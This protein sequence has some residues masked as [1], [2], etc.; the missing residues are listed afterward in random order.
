MES[1]MSKRKNVAIVG[2]TGSGK[3]LLLS[4]FLYNAKVFDRISIKQIDTDPIEEA[5]GSSVTSHV[6]SFNWKEDL[7][8]AI[9][10]PGFGD[11]IADVINAIFVCENVLSVINGVAGVEIQTERTWQIAEDFN[12]PVMVFVNQLDKERSSF[13]NS[14]ESLKSSFGAKVTPL[15]LPI[16]SES[17]FKGVVDLIKMK[18]FVYQNGKPSEIPI[19]DDLKKQ[20]DEMRLKMVEDIVES[21]DSLMEKYLEGQEISSEELIKALINAYKKRLVIPVFCGSAEKNI[22]IDV[23]LDYISQIGATPLDCPKYKA[24]LEDGTEIEVQVTPNEPFCAYNFKTIVDPF[25]GRV[26]YIKVIAGTIKPGDSYVNVNR[27]LTDKFG[28]L[29]RAMG[30][31][32]VEVEEAISGD[33]IV[34]PKLKEGG[35]GETLAHR[36]RK[37]MIIPPAF[38]EPMFSRSVN[39]KS[40]TDID[41]IS[42]GLSRLAET[43]PTF[44]WEYDPETGETVVSGIGTVHLDTMIERLKTIFG[45]DVEVGKPKIAYRETITKKVVA[46]YKHKKQTGGHGQYG[47]VKIEM[48][49][50]PRGAGFEFVDKI[51]GGAI[52][53]NYIPAV[54]KGIIE[55][56][57]RGSLAGYPVVDVR[58]TLFDGSYHEVD[59]SDISF[60]IAA[61]QAFRKGMEEAKPV[62]LEPIM[63]VEVFCPDEVAGDVIG[64]ITARRGRPQGMEPVGRG[65]SK[66]KAEVPLAEMLDF[67]GRLSGLTSGRGYFT[68]RF[69]KY[70]EVPP[71]IQEKIVQERKQEREKQNA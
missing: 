46:E 2:H 43:D 33:I 70:Q 39:P 29:Y 57:K 19:P 12:R 6:F 49:P 26:S 58:V 10:T 61:I 38:P 23:L 64:D 62:L 16:G 52:P 30:K 48:E 63:E 55:A 40:K 25:V 69:L 22:G 34:L 17:D 3:S 27:G 13:E 60:Q 14:V 51:F 5:K 9:D 1:V 47:H 59:S 68:M 66:I 7:F 71:N 28:R 15:V 53:K 44:K 8:T 20:A 37:I 21:D 4:A 32:Q 41:K 56:M 45:V 35:V 36:D 11:F 50:L 54:E 31:E 65:M 67:S 18:A 42:N 24:K